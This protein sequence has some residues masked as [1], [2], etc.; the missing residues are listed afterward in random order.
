MAEIACD[1]GAVL[2]MRA[3]VGAVYREFNQDQLSLTAGD[4]LRITTTADLLCEFLR[5]DPE[6]AQQLAVDEVLRGRR[7]RVIEAILGHEPSIGEFGDVAAFS[8][9]GGAE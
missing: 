3:T 2:A 9:A 6:L 8:W 5:I 4:L 7:R 1:P